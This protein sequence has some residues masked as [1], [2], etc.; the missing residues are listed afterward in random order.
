MYHI[1]IQTKRGDYINEKIHIIIAM[2]KIIIATKNKKLADKNPI[3]NII[4]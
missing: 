4:L 1:N 3:E 2:N